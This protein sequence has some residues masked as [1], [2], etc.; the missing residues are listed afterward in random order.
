MGVI[1]KGILGGFQNKVGNVVGTSWK[2]IDV[3]KSLPASVANPRTTAQVNQRNRFA[4]CV[5]FAQ[6][7]LV[8]TIKPLWDRFAQKQSGYNAFVSANIAQFSSDGELPSPENLVISRGTL[9]PVNITSVVA[10]DSSNSITMNYST[11]NGTNGAA[12]DV[13]F[14]VIVNKTTGDLLNDGDTDSFRSDGIVSFTSTGFV[15]GDEI[16]VLVAARSADGFRVSDTTSIV[17]SAVA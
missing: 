2:G 7:I 14:A 9:F 12:T 11:Q 3:M 16:A 17:V 1:K 15:T 4:G 10:D 5:A 13:L 8:S 6:E